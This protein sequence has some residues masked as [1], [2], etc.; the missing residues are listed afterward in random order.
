MVKGAA[1]RTD[2][3]LVS[4]DVTD[5]LP[6]FKNIFWKNIWPT[7]AGKGEGKGIIQL[8]IERPK[9]STVNVWKVFS[10]AIFWM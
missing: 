1:L 6:H 7:C 2:D 5:V 9:I 3:T 10:L 8:G 4:T